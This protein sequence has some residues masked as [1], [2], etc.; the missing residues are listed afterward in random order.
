MKV[1]VTDGKLISEI[2]FDGN[3]LNSNMTQNFN[4]WSVGCLKR[5]AEFFKK[6]LKVLN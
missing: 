4:I 2:S 3:E 6:W 5:E 1:E